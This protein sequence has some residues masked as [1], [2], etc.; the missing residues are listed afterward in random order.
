MFTI[1]M[2]K[3]LAFVRLVL[4]TCIAAP[5]TTAE[6]TLRVYY[7]GNS[8]TDA[9]QYKK[10]ADIARTKNIRIEWGRHMI[11]GAP[12]QWIWEHPQD[13]FSEKPFGF[14][15]NALANFEWD[16]VTLQPFDRQL[17]SDLR[18]IQQFI[19]LALTKSPQCRFFLY[20]RWPRM[21][22]GGKSVRFNQNDYDP[23]QRGSGRPSL[24]DLDDWQQRWLAKYTGQWDGTN[25]SRDYFLQLLREVRAANPSLADRVRLIPVGDVMAQLDLRMRDGKVP[26]S[27]SIWQFYKDGI[28]MAPNGSYVVACTFFAAL[29]GLSPEGLPHEPYGVEDAALARLIQATAWEIVSTRSEP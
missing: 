15:S 18:Y 24:E 16:I 22:I 17:K 14:Y 13:G 28:H 25:E 1:L 4:A 20:S 23:N 9:L 21:T 12:L 8:V 3:I 11:P 27:R 7:I 29:T 6:T 26:G 10:F 19:D 5:L 2:K